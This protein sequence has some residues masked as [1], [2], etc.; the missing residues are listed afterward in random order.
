V[1]SDLLVLK[2]YKESKELQG[3]LENR[4]KLVQQDLLEKLAI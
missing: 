3:L 4:A 1:K 2:E